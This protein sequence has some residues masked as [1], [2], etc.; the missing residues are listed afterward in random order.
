MKEL[1]E[2]VA[3]ARAKQSQQI[4]PVAVELKMSY[5]HA[6]TNAKKT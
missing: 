5:S 2:A 1:E 4:I 3:K 6:V